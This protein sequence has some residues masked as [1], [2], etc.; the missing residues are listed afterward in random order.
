MRV[1]L[2]F[3]IIQWSFSLNLSFSSTFIPRSYNNYTVYTMIIP[4]HSYYL[5]VSI[6]LPLSVASLSLQTIR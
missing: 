4:N 3:L 2:V 5:F 6:L 1:F